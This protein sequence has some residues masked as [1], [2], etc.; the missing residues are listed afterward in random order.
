MGS[1][2]ALLHLGTQ[3]FLNKIIADY[4]R[5]GCQPLSAVAGAHFDAIRASLADSGVLLLHNP[6]PDRGPFSS[7]KIAI[8]SLP[9][10]CQGFFV[11]PVDHPAVNVKTLRQILA[12][13]TGES[14]QVTKPAFEGRGGHPILLGRDWIKKIAHAPI[15]S[16]LRSLLRES[17]AEVRL[18]P[19]SDGMILLNVNQPEDLD[20]ISPHD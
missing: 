5:L 4:R 12:A 13:W 15:S 16:D 10:E 1:P 11:H 6:D 8:K 2:K 9:P 14:Q 3:T 18:V 17:P 19:V 7:L 20:K